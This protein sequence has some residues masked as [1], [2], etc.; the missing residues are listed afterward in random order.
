MLALE[1]L[2]G[3]KPCVYTSGFDSCWHSLGTFIF[4]I[5]VP[6]VKCVIGTAGRLIQGCTMFLCALLSPIFHWHT[7]A[8]PC[9]C[10]TI[11]EGLE[12]PAEGYQN[13]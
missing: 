8:M 3:I 11:P 6:F 13:G 2:Y 10:S 7:P 1:T 5:L 12:M 4:H 9:S